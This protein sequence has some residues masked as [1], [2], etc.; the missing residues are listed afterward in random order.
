MGATQK[1]S[2]GVTGDCPIGMVDIDVGIDTVIVIVGVW[3]ITAILLSLLWIIVPCHVIDYGAVKATCNWGIN[4]H[5]IYIY[6]DQFDI[7]YEISQLCEY[8]RKYIDFRQLDMQHIPIIS[9]MWVVLTI[10]ILWNDNSRE[11]NWCS[12]PWL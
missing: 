12:C 9:F 5:D 11:F 10:P 4:R 2:G 8:H 7:C 3:Q 1:L 6:N